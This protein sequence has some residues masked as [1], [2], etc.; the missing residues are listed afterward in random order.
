M[1]ADDMQS[2]NVY[3]VSYC[4][5]NW[6]SLGEPLQTLS[7]LVPAHESLSSP[8]YRESFLPGGSHL[9]GRAEASPTLA[10]RPDFR[11][12]NI[13][14]LGPEAKAA[15]LRFGYL[16]DDKVLAKGLRSGSGTISNVS[17]ILSGDFTGEK[18]RNVHLLDHLQLA[19][20]CLSN[21]A[22][23]RAQPYSPLKSRLRSG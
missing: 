10:V 3:H 12:W 18:L 16:L 19:A 17:A 13:T 21:K 15:F 4:S 22:G 8:K 5:S 2:L 9:L 6:A 7:E 14:N 23:L 20:V 1:H 11:L